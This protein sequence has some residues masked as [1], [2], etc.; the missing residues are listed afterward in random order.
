M[1]RKVAPE[2]IAS[3][4]IFWRHTR[5]IIYGLNEREGKWYQFYPAKG[6]EEFSAFSRQSYYDFTAY[7]PRISPEEAGVCS[8][9]LGMAEGL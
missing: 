5:G 9:G 2:E 4:T 3:D 7:M 8:E 1:P 6:W